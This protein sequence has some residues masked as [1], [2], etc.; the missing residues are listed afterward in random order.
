MSK[1]PRELVVEMLAA[2]EADQA[3][4]INELHD[5]LSSGEGLKFKAKIAATQQR[6]V[7]NGHHDQVLGGLIRVL[8]AVFTVAES[9]V[10]RTIKTEAIRDIPVDAPVIQEAVVALPADAPIEADAVVKYAPY[11]PLAPDTEGGE[12]V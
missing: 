9:Q 10:Q 1:S 7:P 6:T 4:A 3:T 11:L 12:V 8:D 2:L 5:Y